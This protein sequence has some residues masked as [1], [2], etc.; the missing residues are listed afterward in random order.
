MAETPHPAIE[1][2]NAAVI[3]GGASGIGLAAA[4]QFSA[5]GM[6]VCL[7]DLNEEAL[8][9][10]KSLCIAGGEIETWATDVADR[11]SLDRLAQFVD[12]A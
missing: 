11:A 3:T 1:P 2:G 6:N 10:A 5:A 9:A 7:A 8:S 4:K 12:Q